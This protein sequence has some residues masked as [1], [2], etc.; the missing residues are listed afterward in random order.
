MT[1][2]ILTLCA[3]LTLLACNAKNHLFEKLES[4]DTG[5]D[6]V[7]RIT[8]TDSINIID[9]ENVYNGGGVA[10]GDFNGDGLADLYFSGNLVP[11]KLYINKG[12]LKFQDVTTI[13]G[14]DGM[15]R[16]GRGVAT[17]DVNN[18]GKLDI[19]LCATLRKSP[20]ERENMLY[21]NQGNDKNG[22]P[23]FKEMGKEYGLADN[24]QSTMAAFF[25]YDND[26]DLDCYVATNEIVEG[27]FP[28]RFRPILTDG[29]HANTDR[30][31]RNDW[32]DSLRHPV[33]TN[34]SKEA[35]IQWEGYAHGLNICDIN[36]DGWKDI[37][38]SND[39]LSGNEFYINNRNGTFTNRVYELLKHSSANAM[40]N[41]VIDINNDGLSDII[42]LDMNPEDN[43][44]KKMM[45]NPNSYQTYQNTDYFNY[46]YQYVRNS[47]QVNLGNVV[48]L[49]DSLKGPV[50]AETSYFSGVAET[51]W[52]WTPSVADFD[53]DGL[54]D[55][56]ISN[57]FP[58]DVTD[59]DFVAYRDEAFMVASKK[60]LLDQI[61]EVKINNYAYRNTG[62][63]KFEDKT[64]EWG[65]ETPSFSNGAIYVDL[66]N[67]GDLDYVCSNI[68]D[69]P[70]V[71]RNT[72]NDQEATRLNYTRIKLQGDA[73]NT[74]GLGAWVELYAD[75]TRQ[76]Y[77]HS[78][79]RGYLS[80][81]DNVIHF[82][83][84]KI[85]AIDSIVVKWH[86]GKKQT[87]A[88]PAI[89]TLL[90]ISMDKAD[91][92][93]SWDSRQTDTATIFREVA[94][95]IDFTQKE[96]DFID[97]NIQKLLPHK[98]S[99]YGPALVAGDIN[100]DGLDD[101]IAGGSKSFSQVAFVQ[102]KDGSFTSR[103]LL[104]DNEETVK[105]TED[106]GLLLLDADRDGDLDLY[107]ASG[108][109]ENLP[110]TSMHRDQV[111]VNDG[112]GNFTADTTGLPLN[113]T[114]KSCVKA[115]DFDHDG[116]LDLFL[117]GRVYPGSWPK[118]VSSYIYRNDSREGKIRFTDVTKEVAPM[119]NNIGMVCDA[120]WTDVDNDGWRDLLLAGEFMPVTILKNS[121]GKFSDITP[122][123]GIGKQ[124]GWWNS[125]AAGDF[126]NDGDMDYVAGNLGLNTFYKASDKEPVVVLLKDFDKN[127]STDAIPGV[128]TKDVANGTRKLFPVHT[129]DD[130]IK[131]IISFRQKFPAYK[132]YAKATLYD[133]F[134]AEE[135]KD[136]VELKANDMRSVLIR[137]EGGGKFSMQ[138]LP[139]MAQ[140]SM[141]NGMT[142]E[143]VNGDGNLDILAATN[144][145]GTEVT[146]G[147]YD[148]LNGLVLLGNGAGSFRPAPMME[149]GICLPADGKSMIRIMQ[150][151]GNYLLLAGQNKGALK[152]WVMR[153][154]AK[155]LR[156][157]GDDETMEITLANGKKRKQEL[158][159]GDGF[160]SQSARLMKWNPNI[161]GVEVTNSQ[162]QK[163]T[164]QP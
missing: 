60:Q 9:Q 29:S 7:N 61:P 77:E 163:R 131:Q 128:Y 37:Y 21:V 129:R 153:D 31:Y 11:S 13:A 53:N 74:Q 89:N 27:D 84:G 159:V 133:L 33:F 28:N 162:N 145:Y 3:S 42:E 88:K 136:V 102:K 8:E 30:L 14:V 59:H 116:D 157:N 144:D 68:N 62:N 80:T 4:S 158:Y 51:D 151:N 164:I 43:Y 57:G 95:L 36:M 34:V 40:G 56:I 97:F 75:S 55:I 73:K 64:K 16:W 119:L 52:S 85:Q 91:G 135:M 139:D 149:S 99:Q 147:R 17:V 38:V 82:G 109:Y 141:I 103:K 152:T 47:L 104:T 83:L 41:D 132:P 137:N 76:V 22:V 35:G 86:G 122:A 92:S 39:Y 10:A 117:G 130:M 156:M 111:Y 71:Y 134:T 142:V 123:S 112:K 126:D 54:R 20:A 6:F 24:G 2:R 148:A 48:G 96:K 66:D 12:G 121:K 124:L 5:I 1:M 100:G 101:V 45:M 161:K 25:D 94:G 87:I 50:F 140:W 90:T 79:Y 150:A 93:Y 26:G 63:V 78:P 118:A 113:Y 44:R 32:N 108:T 127:N 107:V 115:A 120:L 105:Q 154:P 125:L 69:A 70:F 18:D 19:Y 143:D 67:D 114:S 160:L 110:N 65:F 138:A 146:V 98:L 72:T 106:M 49:N 58:K 23:V 15:G 46:P 155:V 81:V